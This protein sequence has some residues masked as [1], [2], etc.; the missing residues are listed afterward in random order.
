MSGSMQNSTAGTE[1]SQ[2]QLLVEISGPAK[3][4][5]RTV[6]AVDRAADLAQDVV[7]ECLMKL[8]AGPLGIAPAVLPGLVSGLVKWRALDSLRRRQTD[9]ERA[10]AFARDRAQ[11]TRVWMSPDLSYEEEDM[12]DIHAALIAGADTGES[13]RDSEATPGTGVVVVKH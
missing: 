3:R 10:H 1:M 4:C 8:R 12:A 11:G 7:L 5:V 9:E 6:G 2:A 13:A